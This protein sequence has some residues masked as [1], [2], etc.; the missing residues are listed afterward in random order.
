[1]RMKNRKCPFRHL[2]LLQKPIQRR[3]VRGL[4]MPNL[5]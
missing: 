4:L 2:S 5:S 1:M 3:V